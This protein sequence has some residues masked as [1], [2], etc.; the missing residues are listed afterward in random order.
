MGDEGETSDVFQGVV[1]GQLTVHSRPARTR[2]A[3]DQKT[4]CSCRGA[5]GRAA[6]ADVL[7]RWEGER[8]EPVGS[9]GSCGVE[10]ITAQND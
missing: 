9:E 1:S 2:A 6:G 3:P 7:R 10:V 8:S 5:E 4:A